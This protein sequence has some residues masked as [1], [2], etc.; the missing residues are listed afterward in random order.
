MVAVPN[1]TPRLSDTPGEVSS[2]G[3]DT[4]ADTVAVL[5]RMLGLSTETLAD[6]QARG[7]IHD[8]QLA[9]E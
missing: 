6:L 3:R 2:L 8:K 5:S 7:V 9:A 4:G 1:V